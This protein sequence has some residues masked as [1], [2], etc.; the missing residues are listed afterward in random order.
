MVSKVKVLVGMPTGET[1]SFPFFQ[2]YLKAVHLAEDQ[3]IV[4]LQPSCYRNIC[5]ARNEIANVAVE[6]DFTHVFF[7]DSDMGFPELALSRLLQHDVDVVGGYYNRK[8]T[9]FMPNVFKP[10]GDSGVWSTRI[11]EKKLEKVVAIGTGC[12]LI[13]V[14]VFRKI[15]PPWF[16]YAP[17]PKAK[18]HLK[19]EDVVFCERLTEAGID[20]YCDGTIRCSHAAVVKIVP[21]DNGKVKVEP[22]L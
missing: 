3:G 5:A 6:N 20:I 12:L 15:E 13:K 21:V 4:A 8:T 11:P 22:I 1:Y 7:M 14:D 17:S 10:E 16:L 19:T 9:G 18:H 2:S